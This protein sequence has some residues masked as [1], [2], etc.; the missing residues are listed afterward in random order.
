MIAMWVTSASAMIGSTFAVLGEYHSAVWI[1]RWSLYNRQTD[2]RTAMKFRNV[3][4]F[5]VT[6]Q[7]NS[8]WTNVGDQKDCS[9]S[10]DQNHPEVIILIFI[11]TVIIIIIISSPS[12]WW[13]SSSPV[14]SAWIQ[15]RRRPAAGKELA[16][17]PSVSATLTLK[18]VMMMMLT[19]MM[20][21]KCGQWHWF[22]GVRRSS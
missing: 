21:A 3:W 14:S 11:T 4:M 8:G 5:K 20:M 22:R 12:I 1:G 17:V 7:C 19:M 2:R 18:V 15:R 16:N 10:T 6:C 9:C 13:S